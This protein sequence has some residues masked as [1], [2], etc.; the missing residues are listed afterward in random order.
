MEARDL[1]RPARLIPSNAEKA[2]PSTAAARWT[3][4]LVAAREETPTV[5]TFFFE[6]PEI[7]FTFRPGQYLSL[8]LPG[9]TDPRGDARTFSLSSAPSDRDAVAITTRAGPSPFKQRLFA[10]DPGAEAELWGPFGGFTLAPARAGVLI[11][12]GIGITPYRSMIREAVHR[13]SAV[14]LALLYSSRGPAELVFR[15]EL[16]ELRGSWPLLRLHLSVTRPETGPGAWSGPTGRIDAARVRAAMEGL[17]DPIFYVC[18]PPAMV[19]GLRR[20]L[21]QE[22]RIPLANVR[23][24]SFPGYGEPG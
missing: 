19:T 2:G 6:R 24:E 22:A 23:T 9:V 7:A 14:P 8:R 13:R 10:I 5:R 17:E 20:M 15:S 21:G 11:G 3:G 12:G 18:G 4:R 1:N 16:E